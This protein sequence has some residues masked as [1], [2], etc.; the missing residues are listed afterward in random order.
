VWQVGYVGS[1]GRKT[2][3]MLELNPGYPTGPFNAEYPNVGSVY[4]LNSIGNSNYNALQTTLKIRTWHGVTGQFAF[5]WAHALDDVTEY[6]GVIPLDS[7]NL[8]QEYGSSDFDT[9]LNFT[10]FLTYDIPGSSHG[11]KWLSHGWQLSG[12]STA[13]SRSTSTP[14]RNGPGWTSSAIRSPAFP[15]RSFRELANHG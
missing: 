2:S 4:Q 12:R 5:T 11:P 10:T 14:G 1:L 7:Y 13:D 8:A 3:V 15:T 9:R 6:R